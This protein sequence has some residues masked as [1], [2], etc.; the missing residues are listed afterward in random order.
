MAPYE[1]R[2]ARKRAL[3]QTPPT[4]V[5]K[6]RCPKDGCDNVMAVLEIGPLGLPG[7]RIVQHASYAEGLNHPT[8]LTLPDGSDYVHNRIRPQ[9]KRIDYSYTDT[10]DPNDLRPVHHVVCSCGAD[11]VVRYETMVRRCAE[12]EAA[13][14]DYVYAP[15]RGR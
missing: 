15:G 12:A 13:G 9:I 11:H 7:K 4:G 10:G 2:T 6:L 8:N 14:R 5:F 1:S 3:A